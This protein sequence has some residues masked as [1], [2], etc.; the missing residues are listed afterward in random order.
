[1][2]SDGL[3]SGRA[4]GRDGL[5]CG[6]GQASGPPEQQRILFTYG[7]VGRGGDAVQVVEMAE[8][9]RN[10]GHTVRL[11]G[12]EPLRPYEFGTGTSRVRTALRRLPWWA[13]DALELT[14]NCRAWV[15]A[16][17]VMR[18][19]RYDLLF[20]RASIYDFVGARLA[21]MTELPLIVHLDAP[22]AV[23]REF[24]GAGHFARLHRRCMRRIGEKARL[25]VTV[26]TASRDYYVRMGIPREKILVLP[27]GVSSRLLEEGAALARAHPPFSD[28]RIC[29]IGFVG[30]LSRWHRVDLLL[31]ALTE[32]D[33]RFSAVVV[34][35]GA[36]HAR[37][38]A[39]ARELGVEDR[40]RWVGAVPHEQAV[41]E[42]AGFDIAV[43]PGT[44]S[45]GAPLKLF[46]YAALGRPTIAP[47]LPNL[48][49]WFA[50]EEMRFIPPQDP[51]ALAGAIHGLTEA[52][53]EARALGRN[54][55]TRVRA[56]TWEAIMS[57]LV[58]TAEV[59][60]P[61]NAG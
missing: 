14:L 18:Q 61:R 47:D 32:L 28:S 19:E 36:E 4:E 35:Y 24:H 55:Q 6:K 42:M 54:A 48:R 26:S 25:V 2:L 22:F 37:L 29:T 30:S 40:V 16:R 10:L 39:L 41:R 12:P 52:P 1:M 5:S 34:G 49:A 53:D 59:V 56:Y 31:E 51:Q 20:H 60:Q 7:L 45:T 38:R 46:E 33:R 3:R 11:V 57:Q 27:N 23:E 13:K 17:G 8:A 50:P 44:L 21:K 9:L 15:L 43:L 58:A